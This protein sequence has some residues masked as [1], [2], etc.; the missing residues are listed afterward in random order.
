MLYNPYV[1]LPVEEASVKEKM[2]ESDR[3]GQPG[4]CAAVPGRGQEGCA[5]I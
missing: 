3:G 5:V 1:E 4:K 2:S